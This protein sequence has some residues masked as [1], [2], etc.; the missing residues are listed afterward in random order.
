MIAVSIQPGP[1][2]TRAGNDAWAV[3]I[4]VK[5]SAIGQNGLIEAALRLLLPRMRLP[6]A[7]LLP[8]A[9][10]LYQQH[11]SSVPKAHNR[12]CGAT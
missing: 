6:R 12:S 8:V 2:Q 3:A 4:V 10:D 1:R 11:E 5:C 9:F 7:I